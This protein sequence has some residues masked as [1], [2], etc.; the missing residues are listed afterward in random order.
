MDAWLSAEQVA[1]LEGFRAAFA[2]LQRGFQEDS[3]PY[4]D[5]IEHTIFNSRWRTIGRAGCWGLAGMAGSAAGLGL[6]PLIGPIG[7]IV[8]AGVFGSA[9]SVCN[10]LVSGATD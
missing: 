2:E 10:D 7:A 1:V 4:R 8:G 5:I 6:T 3:A 9:A